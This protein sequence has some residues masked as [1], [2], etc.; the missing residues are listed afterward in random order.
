VRIERWGPRLI[1][2]D[3][4]LL[5]NSNVSDVG[6]EIPHPRMLDRAFV[7]VPLAEIA[8]NLMLA[9]KSAAE[10]AARLD[11]EGIER[12]DTGRNWWRNLGE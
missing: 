1:D 10:W 2:I 11:S 8:P 12:L 3:V 4:L 5:G 7:M 9:G 6:L